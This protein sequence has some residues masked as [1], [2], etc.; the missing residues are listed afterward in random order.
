M[1]F[2]IEVK[3]RILHGCLIGD[4]MGYKTFYGP[5]GSSSTKHILVSE[6]LLHTLDFI[7]VM[8]PTELSYHCVVGSAMNIDTIIMEQKWHW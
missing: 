6:D 8:P 1:G 2:C 4:S 3:L 5:R 7:N